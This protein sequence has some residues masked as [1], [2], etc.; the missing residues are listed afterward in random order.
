MKHKRP[1]LISF[2]RYKYRSSTSLFRMTGSIRVNVAFIPVRCINQKINTLLFNIYV[3]G[4]FV[5][6]GSNN[7][8]HCSNNRCPVALKIE[9]LPQSRFDD[10]GATIIDPY[11]SVPIKFSQFNYSLISAALSFENFH[12]NNNK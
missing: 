3:L 7:K 4:S 5:W 9:P 10:R 2:D 11:S 6:L 8:A 12:I 1:W